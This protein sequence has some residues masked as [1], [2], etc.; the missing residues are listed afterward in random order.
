[1]LDTKAEFQELLVVRADRLKD[2]LAELSNYWLLDE[3]KAKQRSRNRDI[4]EED[5]NT[6]YFHALANQ[7]R[8]KKDDSCSRWT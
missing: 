5:M 7:R 6:D 4:C 2:I 1:V 8:R 3:I